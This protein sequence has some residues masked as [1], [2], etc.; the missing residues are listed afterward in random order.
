MSR[1]LFGL[2]C[3]S[4]LAIFFF[5]FFF[6]TKKVEIDLNTKVNLIGHTKGL[7]RVEI[8]LRILF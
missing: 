1:Q 6:S 2:F 5:F 8:F 3:F 4:N 7:S